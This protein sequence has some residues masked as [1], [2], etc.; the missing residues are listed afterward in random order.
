MIESFG[1]LFSFRFIR[2][3]LTGCLPASIGYGV[4]ETCVVVK[5]IGFLAG[6]YCTYSVGEDVDCL[7]SGWFVYARCCYRSTVIST[8][9]WLHEDTLTAG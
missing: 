7:L 6:R 3:T 5:R 2:Y 9:R 1:T 4:I 8:T